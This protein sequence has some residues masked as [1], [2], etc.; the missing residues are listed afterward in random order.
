MA[1]SG[2]G[3]G[4]GG[5]S[6]EVSPCSRIIAVSRGQWVRHQSGGGQT[7]NSQTVN[8]PA[9]YSAQ[10]R[11]AARDHGAMVPSVAAPPRLAWTRPRG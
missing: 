8:P 2:V 5:A 4:T 6:G 9:R 7:P 11:Q 3:C 1:S 10:R